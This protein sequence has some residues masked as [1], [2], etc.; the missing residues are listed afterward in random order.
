MRHEPID[1]LVL[2]RVLEAAPVD[3]LVAF[4]Q[5][6]PKGAVTRRI[7]FFYEILTGKTLD[8]EDA[9]AATAVRSL[10]ATGYVEWILG[11]LRPK[12]ALHMVT[13]IDANSGALF[14][15][16]PYNSEFGHRVAF[17]DVDDNART[18]TGDR[19]EFLG[20]NGTLRRPDAMTRVRLSGRLGAALVPCGAIQVPFEL[21][22]GEE[23]TIIFRL[24]AGQNLIQA[25]TLAQRLRQPGSARTTLEKIHQFWHHTTGA[26]QVNTPDKALNLL[27]NGWLVYQTLACRF[28]ARSGFYQ[29]GG[30]FGFRDQ[31]Q[32]A[33]A[34][35]HAQPELLRQHLLLCAARQY[36]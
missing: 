32:D 9:P 19:T 1:L 13:E 7:W 33:M 11:D 25:R 35:L 15:R 3:D 8:I 14:A 26:V 6:T 29:S 4:I 5:S 34:L 21:A 23:R 10:T 20:R 24:G 27:T 12:S 18:L 2:K 36:P 30:A 17:F 22:E 28:C 31:L 16:N